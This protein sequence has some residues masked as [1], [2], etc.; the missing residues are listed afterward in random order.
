MVKLFAGTDVEDSLFEPCPLKKIAS[1][2]KNPKI[3]ILMKEA[4]NE[5]GKYAIFVN[6]Q[7]TK[8]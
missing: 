4:V 1:L 8:E 3:D 2:E 6:P 7:S 5:D